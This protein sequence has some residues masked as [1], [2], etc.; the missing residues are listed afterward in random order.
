MR[1]QVDGDRDGDD[2]DDDDGDGDGG[3]NDGGDDGSGVD[4]DGITMAME[5]IVIPG[6]DHDADV[7]VAVDL[8]VMAMMLT[9]RID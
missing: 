1:R 8:M 6:G 2:G 7:V 5:M 3:S 9:T 4:D